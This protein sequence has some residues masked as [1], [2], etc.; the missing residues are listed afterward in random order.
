MLL[1]KP[2]DVH[3]LGAVSKVFRLSERTKDEE[4]VL[5]ILLEAAPVLCLE[6]ILERQLVEG[7]VALKLF[8]LLG[9]RCLNIDPDMFRLSAPYL[10]VARL[11]I[12]DA[13]AGL[14]W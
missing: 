7:E 13:D 14:G 8:D 11:E 4:E 1:G 2:E 9:R 12:L 10:V 3:L 6:G 5:G